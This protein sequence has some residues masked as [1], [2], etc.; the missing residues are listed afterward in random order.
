[1]LEP[2]EQPDAQPE[3]MLNIKTTDDCHSSPF[4][5]PGDGRSR[6]EIKD[7]HD[8]SED[9]TEKAA[10]TSSKIERAK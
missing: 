4:E 1:M 6:L 2:M 3:F 5:A 10:R 7:G 8:E 9:E